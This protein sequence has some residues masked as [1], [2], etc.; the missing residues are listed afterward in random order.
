MTVLKLI[1]K[2][3]LFHHLK[4]KAIPKQPPKPETK[5]E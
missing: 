2:N 3:L 1:E 5:G 4:E